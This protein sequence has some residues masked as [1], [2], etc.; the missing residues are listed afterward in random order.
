MDLQDIFISNLKSIRKQKHITQEKLAELCSTETAYIGQIET[1]KRFPSISFIE[2]IA[3]A[4]KIDAYLLFK[5]P[6]ENPESLQKIKILK[7]KF[8]NYLENN[9]DDFIKLYFETD[10]IND[11]LENI[12]DR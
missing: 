9:I 11:S 8:I 1:R 2:K 10:F 3:A 7:A 12:S 6:K 4:L 5:N